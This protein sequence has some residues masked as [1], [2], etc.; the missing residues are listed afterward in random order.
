SP[1]AVEQLKQNI[2][3]SGIVGSLVANN[4]KS[5]MI[6]VPLLDK[7]PRTGQ[8][9][10]YHGL[11]R[12]LEEKIRARY[13]LAQDLEKVR[14]R[15]T[16]HIKIH[17]IGFAKLIGELIDGLLKVMLFFAI[18]AAI[19]TAII[20]AYT[21]CVRSTVLVIAC[22]LVAVIW[23]LGL[24]ALFGFELDPFSILVPFLVFAI[25]VSHGAQKMNGIMQDIGR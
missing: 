21:R 17:V 5:S 7:D 10:D 13:E 19:A 11:S 12:V 18:A 20:Y 16:A 25:G 15:E 8:R 4:Y 1:R 22:S 24:V 3:R 6:F 23:Q 2:A 9:I 14:G